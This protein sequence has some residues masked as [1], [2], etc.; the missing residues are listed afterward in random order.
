M[1]SEKFDL[2]DLDSPVFDAVHFLVSQTPEFQE[3]AM[4]DVH[5]Q[6]SVSSHRVRFM[7]IV[8][9]CRYDDRYH[10][11]LW[12]LDLRAARESAAL[13]LPDRIRKLHRALRRL[14]ETFTVEE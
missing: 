12:K 11:S 1:S 4:D 13:P 2:G 7:Q 8:A 10:V 5:I 14:G 3:Y 9:Q 6:G